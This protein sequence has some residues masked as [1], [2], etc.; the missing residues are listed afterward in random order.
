MLKV[1]LYTLDTQEYLV[2]VECNAVTSSLT[3]KSHGA[4]RAEFEAPQPD[5]LVADRDTTHSHEILDIAVSPIEAMIDS[6]DV[7]ND[8]GRKSV[9]FCTTTL[10]VFILR[11]SLS[12]A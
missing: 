8:R 12:R 5:R 11:L 9:G 1:K 3:P 6:D 10:D 7:L 2:K 4:I